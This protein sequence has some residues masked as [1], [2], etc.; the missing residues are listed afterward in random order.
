MSPAKQMRQ[1]AIMARKFLEHQ[2]KQE[3]KVADVNKP[4]KSK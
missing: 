3:K 4:K 2:A 1:I